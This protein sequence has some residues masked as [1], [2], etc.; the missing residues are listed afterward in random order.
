MGRCSPRALATTDLLALGGAAA[1]AQAV[2]LREA[3]TALGGSEL[4]WGVVLAAWLG[5]MAAGARVGCRGSAGG[6]AGPVLLL[7]LALAGVG[8]LRAA[9]ALA[10]RAPGEVLSVA[11]AVWMWLAA[12]LPAAGVGGWAFARLATDV[13]ANLAAGEAYAWESLGAVVGGGAFTFVLAPAGSAAAVVVAAAVVAGVALAGRSRTWVALGVA[14]TLTLAA[15]P[16]E[17]W[18]AAEGWR[19]S[20]RPGALAAA[21]ST[22]LQRLEVAAGSPA[23]LYADGRLLALLPDPHRAA[24]E[25]H[26]LAL[27]HPHPRR[28]LLVGAVPGELEPYLLRHPLERLDVVVEDAGLVRLLRERGLQPRLPPED[29]GRLHITPGDPLHV[30]R[31]GG[32]WDLVILAD[33]DPATLRAHRTRSREFLAACRKAMA[34]GGVLAMRVG[35][36]D[37]YVGGMGGALIATLAATVR[38]ELP[39]VQAIPGEAVW[40]V[41]AAG[42]LDLSAEQLAARWRARGVEDLVFRSELLP[43]LLDSARAEPLGQFVRQAEAPPTTAAH[44]RAVLQAVALAEGRAEGVLGRALTK[45]ARPAALALPA[46]VGAWGAWLVVAA[47]RRAASRGGLAA[48]VGFCSMGWWLL[49]LAGWQATRGAVFAEVGAVNAAF[50]AGLGAAALAAGRRSGAALRWLPAVLGSGAALSGAVTLWW[51]WGGSAWSLVPL[52]L[53]AG[54]VTGFAFAGVAALRHPGGEALGAPRAFAAD[55]L[56]AAAGAALLGLVG[57]PVLGAVRLGVALGG[58]CLAA[59]LAAALAR[60]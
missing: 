35:A 18:L 58:L 24:L 8:L 26:L 13:A 28:V 44:P 41:A 9:P 17:R 5:G 19:W 7:A 51:V 22:P 50:M 20:G 31:R 21:R 12:V 49:V 37:T 27:L 34:A 55:E 53:L 36:S 16:I 30:V 33:G 1:V 6:A 52:L 25:A 40:V 60:R 42:E 4:G 46:L 2:L 59:A 45:A 54:A 23:A 29:A 48:A 38:E 32:G 10:G 3:M 57:L 47:W 14:A 43:V 11:H 56:G 15:G 39:A